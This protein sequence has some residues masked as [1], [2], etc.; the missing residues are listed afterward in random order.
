MVYTHTQKKK[1]KIHI[2]EIWYRPFVL[3][4]SQSFVC[5]IHKDGIWLFILIRGPSLEMVNVLQCP[6]SSTSLLEEM[7]QSCINR[8]GPST[9]VLGGLMFFFLFFFFLFHFPSFS[10]CP[11]DPEVGVRALLL[12]TN[13]IRSMRRI[14][15]SSVPPLHVDA[16]ASLL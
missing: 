5:N 14:T 15:D 13:Q 9:Q 11:N 10:Y 1:K 2:P 8:K 7:E 6:T 3:Y 12:T 16:A 4:I